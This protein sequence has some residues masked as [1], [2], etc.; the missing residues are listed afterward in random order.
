M[1]VQKRFLLL[2][3]ASVTLVTSRYAPRLAIA[4]SFIVNTVALFVAEIFALVVWWTVVY[5]LFFSPLRH[6]PQPKVCPI[7]KSLMRS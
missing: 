2:L 1:A 6:L 7:S 4:S 3:A 5:P